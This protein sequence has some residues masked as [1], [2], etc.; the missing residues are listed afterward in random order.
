VRLI[1]TDAPNSKEIVPLD[2]DGE[3]ECPK[4]DCEQLS[5]DG[6]AAMIDAISEAAAVQR[7]HD[8]VCRLNPLLSEIV[9]RR[10]GLFGFAPEG[11]EDI[12]ERMT[13]LTRHVYALNTGALPELRA[14]A[15]E[16]GI[17]S[18]AVFR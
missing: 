11:A 3:I 16:E 1:P 2:L 7:R 13:L 17:A 8:W 9:C 10:F 12:A 18:E 5:E 4:D 14:M 6:Y 15:E